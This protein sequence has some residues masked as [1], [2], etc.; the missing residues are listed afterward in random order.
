MGIEIRLIFK[1]YR[2]GILGFGLILSVL[3][4]SLWGLAI[5]FSGL[6]IA[7]CHNVTTPDC[8]A[9][10]AAINAVGTLTVMLRV[11]ATPVAI[12]A[13]VFL[14]VPIIATEIERG[15]AVLPWTMSRSRVRWLLPRILAIGLLLAV[16]SAAIGLALDAIE[17]A[18]FPWL[19]VTSNLRDYE[20]R[21]WLVPV[22]A[23]AGL[24]AG[25]L[26]GAVLGR[27]LPGLLAGLAVAAC[28]TGIA[29]VLGASWN[30][31]TSAVVGQDE[32]AIVTRIV[33]FDSISGRYVDYAEAEA[34]VPTTDPSFSERYTEVSLGVP[35]SDSPLVVSRE[36]A[37]LGGVALFLTAGAVLVADRRKPY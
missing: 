13:G 20:M 15:T 27:A 3:A 8:M 18:L 30:E 37:L 10:A 6:G 26:A 17:Q 23:I 7:A 32:G 22:R 16:L 19:A 29:I 14:G 28:V 33:L 25:L 9:V 2:F 35:G 5:Y 24:G 21:G 11:S 12:F 34:T 1:Q 31:A 4:A 36:S